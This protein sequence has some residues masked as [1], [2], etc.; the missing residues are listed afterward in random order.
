MKPFPPDLESASARTLVQALATRKVSALELCDATI[1]RIEQRNGAI[2]AVVVHDFE[3]ARDQARAADVALARG[4]RRP[5]LGM[6]MTVKESFNV[7]GLPTTW[8][9]EFARTLPPAAQDAAAVSRLKAAGAVI[10]GK[11]NVALALGDFESCNPIYGRTLNPLNPERSPGGSS[12]GSAAALACAMVP[13]ELG[14]DAGGSIRVPAH[15]CGVYGHKPTYGLIPMSGHHVP[16]YPT[17]PDILS[18]VGPLARSAD[19]LDLALD[20]LAGPD[21]DKD[22]AWRLELPAAHAMRPGDL[23]VLVLDEHPS[24]STSREVRDAVHEAGQRLAAAGAQVHAASHGLPDLGAIQQ[25]YVKLLLTIMTRGAP[26]APAPISAHEWLGLLDRRLLLRR[27][28]AAFFANVDV[29]LAPPFGTAA[30][31]H[32]HAPDWEHAMLDIDGQPTPYRDQL[33]WSGIASVPGLPATVA[34]VTRTVCGLPLGV[35]II[36]APWA[37]RTTIAVARWLTA[38]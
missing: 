2:N 28:W 21:A 17:A 12:G 8:G 11:T 35:Q 1:A 18:T 38:P 9:F 20:V 13:L 31:K 7:A 26:D 30:F 29:V 34:P 25:I 5:L 16:G 22:R 23:R 14:S 3:R 37:D 33:A 27:Q 32:L 4:E 19:D 10:M 24:A 36:G 6:P 15:F